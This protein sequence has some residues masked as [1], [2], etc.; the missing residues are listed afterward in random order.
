M[1]GGVSYTSQENL[2]LTHLGHDQ[3][4]VCYQVTACV[5]HLK[6]RGFVSSH[7]FFRILEMSRGEI[8]R[9][10]QGTYL[11]VAQPVRTFGAHL[12]RR[13]VC[14]MINLPCVLED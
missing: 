8:D 2:S 3:G 14:V 1:R 13:C 7:F 6:H 10:R 11:Q 5:A 12:L 4:L 9:T